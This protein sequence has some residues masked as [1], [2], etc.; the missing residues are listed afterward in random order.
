[1]RDR[2]LILQMVAFFLVGTAVL[3]FIVLDV[4]HWF[5]PAVTTQAKNVDRLY[6]VMLIVSVPIFVGVV[7]VILFSVW[8][9]HMRPGQENLDG[10]PIHG[11][12]RLEVVWTAVPALL[13]MSLC[14]YAF[15]VLQT[16]EKK[17][18]NEMIVDVTGQQFTWTFSYPQPNGKPPIKAF[19]LY[20][21][22]NAHVYFRIHSKDV[23]HS[24][25]IPAF[26]LQEDA[27]PGI[28]TSYRATL[29]STTGTYP[30]V[31]A[32]L[33]GL[34]HT[35]M[36]SDVHILAPAQFAAWEKQAGAPVA[37]TPGESPASLG[38]QLFTSSTLG[39]GGCHTIADAGTT[40]TIGPRLAQVLKGRFHKA[41]FILRQIVT[42][43]SSYVVPG[44][45][46]NVMPKTFGSVLTPTELSALV[47]YLQKVSK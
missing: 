4:V 45:P 25:W 23:I 15:T 39:C 42:G 19:E 22:T 44:Y 1:M 34:G 35:A 17:Q 7:T 37:A 46:A 24:F 47:A 20:L 28:T 21:P 6:D 11:N 14:I 26:R 29:T 30:I 10:P 12:T 13:L 31:C 3:L 41:P 27:V 32:V 40:G 16:D 18:P 33:C 8:K 5:P 9:F 2:R 43:G 38:K 36:R